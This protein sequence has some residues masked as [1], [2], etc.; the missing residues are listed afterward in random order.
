MYRIL[1]TTSNDRNTLEMIAKNCVVNKKLSPCVHVIDNARSFYI[2]N[3]NFV[4][5]NEYLLLVKCK[6]ENVEKI[7]DIISTEH[8]HDV[9][10]IISL[11]FDIVSEKYKE[12]FNKQ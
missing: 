2:W 4:S 8:N 9:P 1:I 6:D 12:W 7:K 10:E 3:D 5:E 11:H